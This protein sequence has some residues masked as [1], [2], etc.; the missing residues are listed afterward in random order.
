MKED[1]FWRN[2]FYRVGLIRQQFELQVMLSL[3]QETVNF[4]TISTQDLQ[5]T[6]K[7]ELGSKVVKGNDAEEADIKDEARGVNLGSRGA[8][9]EFVSES[10]LASSKD[11]AEAD[12]SIK[13]LGVAGMR[14]VLFY[15]YVTVYGP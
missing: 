14:R 3:D 1:E 4:R 2:Y 12:E 5:D 8:D 6:D 15:R 13:K 7:E 9:E 11:I 10:Y